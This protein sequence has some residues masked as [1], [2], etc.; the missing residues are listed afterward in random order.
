MVLPFA[1]TLQTVLPVGVAKAGPQRL[2]RKRQ[3][4]LFEL[5]VAQRAGNRPGILGCL[6]GGLGLRCCGARPRSAG[7]L[8]GVEPW[9]HPTR[10]CV[11]AI[12]ALQVFRPADGQTLAAPALAA[13]APELALL[14]LLAPGRAAGAR[15]PGPVDRLSAC[16]VADG[17]AGLDGA[18]GAAAREA[19][20]AGAG[21]ERAG[22]VLT[23][24]VAS[25]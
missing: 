25:S 13:L 23:D 9:A 6:G 21:A 10:S 15:P 11:R 16:S 24:T 14:L 20:G 3:R 19:A 17:C 12:V 2:G 7:P 4:A 18:A 5:L 1:P 22:A 8:R